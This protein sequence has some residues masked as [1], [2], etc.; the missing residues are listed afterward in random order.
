MR[1]LIA[2]LCVLGVGGVAQEPP[3]LRVTT[4]LVQINVVVHDRKGQPAADL[5]RD[6]FVLLDQGQ[7]QKI[8]VF[9]VESSRP[10]PTPGRPAPAKTAPLPQ[11]YFSNRLERPSGTPTTATVILFDGLNTRFEDQVYARSELVKYL[12]QIQPQDRVALYALGRDL[13]VLHDFT[14]DTASLLRVLARHRGV[15]STELAASEPAEPDTGSEELD[16]WLGG[17]D[18]LMAD[19]YT[20]NRTRQTLKAI[21]AIAQHVSRLP[22]RK[23]LIWLSG[24]FPF[25]IG[26][27]DLDELTNPARE[28]RQFADE[29]ERTARALNEANLAIYPV[30]ARGLVGLP[31]YSATGRKAPKPG[32]SV[33]PK[34]IWRNQETMEALAERTGGEAFYNVNDLKGAIRR[35]VEDAR[36]TYV[37]GYYPTHAS[38][39]GKFREV[40]VQVKRRGLNV[41]HRAGYFAFPERQETPQ[42]RDEALREAVWSPLEATGIGLL[43]RVLPGASAAST[44]WRVATLVEPRNITLELKGEHWVGTLDA[45]FV[46]LS[47]EG[48]NL[49]GVTHTLNFDLTR[50]AY[51]RTMKQGAM[52]VKPLEIAEGA[53]Q[54]R[55]IVRDTRTGSVGS[56]TVPI[57]KVK[58]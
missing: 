40:K 30:D 32:Q 46:Q 28:R 26:F 48:R 4:H 47:A 33:V 29:I 18:Q 39:D 57:G 5:T 12:G 38:W 8:R 56:V 24:G 14:N 23:N 45:L 43:V 10:L 49:A 54:L 20:V 34:S 2:C 13:R 16:A 6:D 37:L 53:A 41:R 36:V 15:H 55:V 25:S 7:P 50:E 35:A 22:G 51:E 27:D 58:L 31:S 52:L 42:Q 44:Q 19:F 11:N 17:V 3:L 21:E 9:S 1:V